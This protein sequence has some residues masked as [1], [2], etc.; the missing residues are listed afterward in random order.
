MQ[1][2]I[3]TRL[4]DYIDNTSNL[5]EK[6]KVKFLI[7]TREEWRKKYQELTG[8]HQLISDSLKL[9]KPTSGFLQKVMNKIGTI[10]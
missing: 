10:K 2:T 3:E 8:V 9:D 1:Q 7:A 5:T 6:S 4:W